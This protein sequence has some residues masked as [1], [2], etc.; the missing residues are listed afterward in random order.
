MLSPCS[1]GAAARLNAKFWPSGRFS[2]KIMLKFQSSSD[3][4]RHPNEAYG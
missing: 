2:P 4:N 3:I 1:H